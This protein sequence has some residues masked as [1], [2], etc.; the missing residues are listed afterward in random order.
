M[1]GQE[2]SADGVSRVLQRVREVVE[3]LRRVA[4]AVEEKNGSTAGRVARDRTRAFDD[5]VT[6]DLQP[7]SY[8]VRQRP[9]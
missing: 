5:P 1:A 7:R 3:G 4:E 2:G 8:P 9:R 6:A